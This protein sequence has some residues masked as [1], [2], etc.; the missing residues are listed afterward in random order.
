MFR[1]SIVLAMGLALALPS[2][3]VSAGP[4]ARPLVD[5]AWL[6]A[7]QGSDN[8]VVL[9]IRN[10]IDGGD[11]ATFESGHIPGAVYSSYTGDGWRITE[12][13]V[14]GK[15][16][17]VAD[18]EALIGGLGIDNDDT[19]VVVPAGVGSTDFGSAARVYWTFKVLGHDR[20]AILD[21]GHR[22]WVEAGGATE[23]GSTEVS[24]TEFRADFQP[25]LL[26]TTDEVQAA[27]EADGSLVDA[28]PAAQYEGEDKHPQARVAGTIPGA[29]SLEESLLVR[30]GTAHFVDRARVRELVEAADIR[31]DERVL[32][33]CN[34]GHWAATAWFA[35]SEVGGYE[36]VAMYDGSMVEWTSDEARPVQ[37]AKRG[38]ARILE[39]FGG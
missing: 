27:I 34:T 25:R 22:A 5:V 29:N 31:T 1:I 9:D 24:A 8:L 11:R 32:T 16:P 6:Q 14:P 13:D 4:D 17:P 15:M 3:A 38:L 10:A 12:N 23:S 30:E 28:R 18:L 35:L 39:F 21:G 20:V 33:F 2:M 7:H 36:D 19:V 37:V 26:A